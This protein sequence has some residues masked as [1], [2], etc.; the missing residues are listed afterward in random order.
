MHS[1]QKRTNGR[2][3]PDHKELGAAA[4]AVRSSSKAIDSGG[5]IATCA[6]WRPR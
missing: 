2:K 1:C 5:S 3:I 4:A 6:P